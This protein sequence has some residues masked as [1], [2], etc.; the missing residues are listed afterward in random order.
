MNWENEMQIELPMAGSVLEFHLADGGR[1]RVDEVADRY[2][3]SNAMV[4]RWSRS[5]FLPR[6]GPNGRWSVAVLKAWELA[7]G[8]VLGGPV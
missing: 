3:R 8:D 6:P 7:A 5:G 2:G 4:R 1:L